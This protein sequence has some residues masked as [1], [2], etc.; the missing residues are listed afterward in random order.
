MKQ[1]NVLMLN[2]NPLNVGTYLRCFFLARELVKQGLS[3]TLICSG[4]DAGFKVRRIEREG[5]RHILLPKLRH[6]FLFG[7]VLRAFLGCWFVLRLRY[8]ILHAFAVSQPATAMPF[9]LARLFRK[10]RRYVVDWDDLWAGGIACTLPFPLRNIEEYLE[11]HVPRLASHVTVAGTM[12]EELALRH[13]P[14]V[15]VARVVNGVNQDEIVEMPGEAARD[16]LNL[17][18]EVFYVGSLGNTYMGRC[19]DV[20]F[21]I[22]ASVDSEVGGRQVRLL[23]IGDMPEEAMAPYRAKHEGIWD[24]IEFAG[25]QPYDRVKLYLRACDVLLLPMED[26]VAERARSPIRLGDY[27]ASGR[28]IVSNAVG[29]VRRTL[30]EYGFGLTADVD[31]LSGASEL[32]Q[33]L[34]MDAGAYESI[35][36]SIRRHRSKLFWSE[37]TRRLAREA[38]GWHEWRSA[39]A[40]GK[41]G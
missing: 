41:L 14:K 26:S 3:V 13:F 28:P 15:T 19:L 39:G 36:E 38:Y 12:L 8:D 33:Q 9:V 10:A 32:L 21:G 1:S 23:M 40:G 35:L 24:R 34:L 5:V 27:V 2:H 25:R 20:L 37:L 29:E 31:D 30:E 16:R 4:D 11:L 18:R 7:H 6:D 17:S 22:F